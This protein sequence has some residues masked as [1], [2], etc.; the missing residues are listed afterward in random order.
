M[1]MLYWTKNHW[2]EMGGGPSI[3][4]DDVKAF[5]LHINHYSWVYVRAG[6][7]TFSTVWGFKMFGWNPL[8]GL[9]MKKEIHFVDGESYFLK[10]R[11]WGNGG[12]YVEKISTSIIRVTEP[13][14]KKEAGTC[15][16]SKPLVSQIDG[17]LKPSENKRTDTE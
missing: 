17:A 15:W 16:F 11:N 2:D 3:Y 8:N 9:N 12:F 1:L 10:L 4:I 14:A 5:N 13:I 6:Q 7:H